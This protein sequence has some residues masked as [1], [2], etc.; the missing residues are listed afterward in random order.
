MGIEN[1]TYIKDLIPTWP[2]GT[3]P[4]SQGDDHLRLIKA[5]LQDQFPG[6]TTDV[7]V[8]VTADHLNDTP[9]SADM[10]LKAPLADPAF[11]GVPT[12]PT[13]APGTDTTQIATTEFVN[14]AAIGVEQTWQVVT[15]SRALSTTYTNSTD[16]PI[17][18][19]VVL[20]CVV[21]TAEA[22]LIIAGVVADRSS[23]NSSY[24]INIKL[25]GIVPPGATYRVDIVATP[26]LNTW[27]ELR[28]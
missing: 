8:T 11:T 15:G 25:S 16:K 5:V 12:A 9:D 19:N 7:A 26:S 21:T 18:V 6:F 27:S 28:A 10:A 14:N 20:L 22:S 4:K 13:A 24:Q 3:D 2:E 17:Q 23:G 1:A